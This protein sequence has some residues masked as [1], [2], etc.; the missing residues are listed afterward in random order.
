MEFILIIISL[1]IFP[2]TQT[3][4]TES[5]PAVSYYNG[6]YLVVYEDNR[7]GDKDI[8]GID[9][10]P[11]S[12]FFVNF[13]VTRKPYDQKNPDVVTT[14]GGISGV[15][16]E[17]AHMSAYWLV[18][19]IDF[20]LILPNGLV[21][22][23]SGTMPLPG[24][25]TWQSILDFVTPMIAFY[26]NAFLV[27]ATAS[28][29]SDW[30]IYSYVSGVFLDTTA[31]QIGNP[32]VIFDSPYFYK[33]P[34]PAVA[35][36]HN[37]FACVVHR[38]IHYKDTL[39]AYYM[40][41]PLDTLPDSFFICTSTVNAGWCDR[42]LSYG[43]GSFLFTMENQG[44]CQIE[45][46][47]FSFPNNVLN[48]FNI[49]NAR[50]HS[51]A[52]AFDKFY[53]FYTDSLGQL[54]GLRIDNSGNIL[55]PQGIPIIVDQN[56]KFDPDVVFDGEKFFLTFSMNNDLYGVFIDSSLSVNVKEVPKISLPINLRVLPSITRGNLSVSFYLSK[57]GEFK[58][59]LFD[60]VGRKS[61]LL[62]RMFP[63]GKHVLQLR[64]PPLIPTG[65]YFLRLRSQKESSVR[66]IIYIKPYSN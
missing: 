34:Y 26:E 28:V 2:L 39:F 18:G 61:I 14:E 57:K 35:S 59:E 7:N 63:S 9:F 42:D 16:Y 58:I 32:F 38:F 55:D 48:R 30:A 27:V 1:G 36:H 17:S 22:D 33:S 11:D 40:E 45:C 54:Y 49:E 31:D 43:E 10:S 41:G 25:A 53:L 5:K 64:L 12:S 50:N 65:M 19:D 66:K 23:T 6:H 44:A 29:I 15:T 47:V 62:R 13:L 56:Q 46:V 8:Y 3:P 60:I 21:R 51:T 52:F 37:G 20:N 24:L 4:W